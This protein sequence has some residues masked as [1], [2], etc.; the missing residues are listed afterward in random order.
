[1]EQT[2]VIHVSL[3][4]PF[5][6]R[7]ET[8]EGPLLLTEQ[9]STSKRLWAFLQYM[10]VF[11]QRGVTQ[12]ELIEALWGDS[13]IGNP[14]NTLKTLLHRGRSAMQQ[15]GFADGKEILLY[16]RGIYSWGSS[17]QLELDIESFDSLC[18]SAEAGDLDSALDAIQLYTGD[19][20]PS[21]SGSPWTISLRTFYHGKYLTL[22][23]ET[24]QKLMDS[25]RYEEACRICQNAT[26]M[27][28][29][30][31]KC[32]LLLMRAMAA[33]GATHAAIQ[34]YTHV[35]A[36]LMDQLGVSPSPEMVALYRE[37]S[38]THQGTEMNLGIIRDQLIEQ[39]GISGAFFCEFEIFQDMYRLLARSCA[40]SGQ[41]AQLTMIAVLDRDGSPL[42]SQR[43]SPVMEVL[44]MSIQQSLRSGDVFTRYSTTQYLILLPSASY[45]NAELVLKRITGAFE[46]TMLG[47][48]A[49]TRCS[50]MPVQPAITDC[51]TPGQFLPIHQIG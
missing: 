43:L 27:D 23:A 46:K 39:Q 17:V 16:R 32:H 51:P 3:L 2:T 9:D 18:E 45:E 49:S 26:M 14:A 47:L 50:V 7:R 11:H 10:A 40:R 24:A 36:L 34:H 6:M 5:S 44:R 13:D 21:A 12:E 22:C 28:A 19:F 33:A 31:E 20:L 30:D 48:S 4:G 15:L 37:L 29:Y 1:M 42:P 41:V 38:K 35:A 25:K 8:A